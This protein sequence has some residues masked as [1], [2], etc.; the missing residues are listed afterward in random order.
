MKKLLIGLLALG[1]S[2]TSQAKLNKSEME[3]IP[4]VITSVNKSGELRT[5][6]IKNK[7]LIINA[8]KLDSNRDSSLLNHF[9]QNKKGLV[10]LYKQ[11]DLDISKFSKELKSPKM[12]TETKKVLASGIEVLK[13]IQQQM[14]LG[15]EEVNY[16]IKKWNL[17]NKKRLNQV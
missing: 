3:L 13:T 16:Y 17:K 1:F 9:E 15:F 10:S 14:R 2:I 4:K 8:G 12:S 7:R 11:C 6:L 5:I